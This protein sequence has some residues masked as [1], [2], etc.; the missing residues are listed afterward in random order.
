MSRYDYES[1]VKGFETVF[2]EA[3]ERG[4]KRG[5]RMAREALKTQLVGGLIGKGLEGITSLIN[6]RAD[7][8]HFSQAPQRARY[9]Q[10]LN[11]RQKIQT[12]LKPYIEQGG[13]KEDYLT[14]YYYD[15]YKTE[16]AVAKPNANVASYDS[17]LREEA[18]KKAKSMIPVFDKMQQESIDVPSFEEFQEQYSKY[19]NQV[20][21]R[22]I[23]GAATKFVKN[24]FSKETD[25]TLAYKNEK[26]KDILYGTSLFKESKEL[27]DA[28]QEWNAEGNGVVDV[29]NSLNEK[30]KNGELVFKDLVDPKVIEWEED[31]FGST[32]T[33]K[34]VLY[35]SQDATGA[36]VEKV[37]DL[38]ID[39]YKEK[40][41]T[42]FTE[43]DKKSAY[44]TAQSVVA[45][46]VK[47]KGKPDDR[48]IAFDKFVKGKNLGL[49]FGSQI[50]EVTNSLG[51]N[52]KD[53]TAQQIATNFLL[54]QAV[55]KGSLVGLRTTMTNWDVATLSPPEEKKETEY[56]KNNLLPNIKIFKEDIQS[57]LGANHPEV[58]DVYNTTLK[59]I[60]GESMN[61]TIDERQE[62][63]RD[64]NKEFGYETSRNLITIENNDGT[65]DEENKMPPKVVKKSMSINDVSSKY[66][67]NEELVNKFIEVKPKVGG[68]TQQ[69]P[70]R[71]DP[72]DLVTND[73]LMNAGYIT[74]DENKF[75]NTNSFKKIY[76]RRKFINDLYKDLNI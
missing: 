29:I 48:T 51:R 20:T 72:I 16:A 76:A 1:Q 64:L 46:F 24:L 75:S 50:L 69:A 62:Y 44:N 33:K 13:N 28:I 15:L 49:T 25:E 31:S 6:Q 67:L 37:K 40:A 45:S 23:G 36:K 57:K 68:V 3:Q 70:G 66:K 4:E 59:F 30:A 9:E 71:T 41:L 43:A 55:E 39:S 27:R 5:K 10:M 8:L 42:Q 38:D 74:E 19:A 17:W 32:I 65:E 73:M 26:A 52:P 21:P 2:S 47:I 34:G 61:L 14:N 22:T 63:I 11:D 35:I 18:N 60:K 53:V 56:L 7:A 58:L 12:T 54:N